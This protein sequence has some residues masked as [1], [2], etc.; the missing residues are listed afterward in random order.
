MSKQKLK[1]Q[2]SC[3]ID[4][5]NCYLQGPFTLEHCKLCQEARNKRFASYSLTQTVIELLQEILPSMR[6]KKSG[7][8]EGST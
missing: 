8:D 6:V 4:A 2:R 5:S 1:P 7:S 3:W